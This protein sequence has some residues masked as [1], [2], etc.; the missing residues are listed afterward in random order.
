MACHGIYLKLSNKRVKKKINFIRVKYTN[1][2]GV[3]V[4]FY[5]EV[6][7]KDEMR[8]KKGPIRTRANLP[9]T[10]PRKLHAPPLTASTCLP[11]QRRPPKPPWPPRRRYERWVTPRATTGHQDAGKRGGGRPGGRT[12]GTPPSLPAKDAFSSKAG[13]E[14]GTLQGPL[15]SPH[16]PN[17]DQAPRQAATAPADLRE[18]P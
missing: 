2:R 5:R 12:E 8:A 9:P 3:C 17:A 7:T 11:H 15:S 10:S 1:H 18:R 4:S 6:T 16:G 13:P 14:G